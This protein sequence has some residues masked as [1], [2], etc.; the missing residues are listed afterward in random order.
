M[1]T[2]WR[3]QRGWVTLLLMFGLFRTAVADWNP[4]PTGSM[5]PTVVEGDVVLVN[6]LAWQAKLPL[7]DVVLAQWGAPE[8]GD[9]VTF[10]SPADGTRLLKR[11]V[12]LPGDR[13][14]LVD[15]QL[16]VNG[17]AIPTSE[18]EW[19]TEA[20]QDD[21]EL[22]AARRQE[23]LGRHRHPVQALPQLSARR[24]G[25]WHVPAGHYF[26]MGDN[27]DNS[28]DSRYFGPVPQARL[29]GRVSRLLASFDPDRFFL[30]RWE[31]VALSL[32]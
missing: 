18:A 31:R 26:M 27:R 3:A 1:K 6:R 5:R 20:V 7:S 25:V 11:V 30:P 21:L 2:W 22:S 17:Q 14:E 13:I 9:I 8:R 19:V 29:I 32:P 24:D 28:L 15:G 10:S 23:Q 12:G 16:W 4:V